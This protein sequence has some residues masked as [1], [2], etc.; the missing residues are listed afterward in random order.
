MTERLL[1]SRSPLRQFDASHVCCGHRTPLVLRPYQQRQQVAIASRQSSRHNSVSMA[2][3]PSDIFV[4]DFDG[5]ICNTQPEVSTAR[6]LFTPSTRNL[7]NPMESWASPLCSP[8]LKQPGV[9]LE[10]PFAWCS[11]QSQATRAHKHTGQAYLPMSTLPGS[12][13]FLKLW[14]GYGQF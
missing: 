12:C 9:L 4:M 5:V 3:I 2:A 8:I 13:R 1:H 7:L 11:C 10:G 6:A 14:R